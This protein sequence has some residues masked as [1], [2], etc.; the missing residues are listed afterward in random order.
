MIKAQFIIARVFKLED[1]RVLFTFEEEK[2]GDNASQPCQATHAYL[3][4]ILNSGSYGTVNGPSI[5]L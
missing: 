4:R 3:S 5:S 2:R 1:R